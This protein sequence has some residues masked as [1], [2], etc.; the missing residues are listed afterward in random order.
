MKQKAA[1][2]VINSLQNGGAER[3]VVNQA[4][5]LDRRGIH[6]TIIMIHDLQFYRLPKT[7]ETIVI[8]KKTTGIRKILNIIRLANVLDLKLNQLNEKYDIVL[9]TANLPYTHYICRFSKY[10][11]KFMFVMHNP[12]YQFSYSRSVLFKK[13]MHFIYGKAHIVAVSEG[14]RDELVSVYGLNATKV[15]TIYNP[16]VFDEISEKLSSYDD[17]PVKYKYILGVGRLGKEKRFDRLIRAFKEGKLFMEYKLVILGI[18]DDEKRLKELVHNLALDE[19]VIFMGWSNDVYNW[20]KNANLFVCSSDYESFGMA[21]VEAL[22][23]NC[24]V[25]SVNSFGPKEILCGNLS[26]YLSENNVEDLA[27]KMVSA[28]EYYPPIEKSYFK[29]FD[30]KKIMNEYLEQYKRMVIS[31]NE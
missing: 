8:S 21:I 24:P 19:Y 29:R 4:I 26:K 17:A 31:E 22:Y 1:V 7:V 10:Y 3:V 30:V 25:V 20:M 15:V 2:F 16:F 11:Q 9:M 5:E 18:G 28:L 12:Q 6:V 13:K 14:V 23:C 27:K